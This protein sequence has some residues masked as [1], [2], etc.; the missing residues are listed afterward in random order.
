MSN[1]RPMS[2]ISKKPTSSYDI[3]TSCVINP[4]NNKRYSFIKY[5]G[6]GKSKCYSVKDDNG[7]FY[8]CKIMKK[9]SMN[10]KDVQNFTSEINIHCT[11][12]HEN[13]VKFIDAFEDSRC[14]YIVTELCDNGSL[15]NFINGKN[16]EL[17]L[18]EQQMKNIIKQIVNAILYMHNN[19][20]V[21]RDIKPHNV[22]L[23]NNM[24]VK[25]GDFGLSKRLESID[26]VMI[27]ICGT[28]NY[29]SP[30]ILSHK[31]YTYKTDMWSLGCTIYYILLKIAPFETHNISNTYIRIRGCL[32][33]PIDTNIDPD[34]ESLI[35]SLLML[36]PTER[37]SLHEILNN[38]YL[39]SINC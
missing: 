33:H 39:L 34:A 22:F 23:D 13:I 36:N 28:P 19:N 4:H 20:I 31:E 38:N 27:E 11:L 30:E 2:R 29:I 15:I 12:S 18:S 10:A 1:N 37:P 21:H 26:N 7:N 8:A 25:I 5:L 14:Y 9:S 17:S 16:K 3:P 35:F 24:N 32:Y 6:K